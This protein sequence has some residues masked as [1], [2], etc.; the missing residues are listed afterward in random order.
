MRKSILAASTALTI[1]GLAGAAVAQTTAPV[2]PLIAGAPPGLYGV[3]GPSSAPSPGNEPGT[4]QAY[5][6]GR[7]YFDAAILSDSANNINGKSSPYS[8]GEAGR[9]YWGFQGTTTSGLTY[10]AYIE[11]RENSGGVSASGNTGAATLIYRRAVGFVAGNWGTFR[12]GGSDDPIALMMTGTFEGIGDSNWNGDLGGLIHA[13]TLVNWPFAENSGTYGNPKFVYLSPRWNGFDF[14]V[15][16]QPSANGIS[17]PQTAAGGVGDPRTT[18]ISTGTFIAANGDLKRERNLITAAAR[19]AGAMGPVGVVA[20]GGI[21]SAT[22]IKNGGLTGTT[23]SGAAPYGYRTPLAFDAGLMFTYGGFAVGGHMVTGAINPN[24]SNNFMAVA[25]GKGST[26]SFVLGASYAVGSWGF[27]TSVLQSLTPGAYAEDFAGAGTFGKR[28][29]TGY[30]ASATYGWAPNAT[31]SLSYIYGA[32]R[33]TGFNFYTS[34]K[35]TAGNNTKAQG[36]I[37]TNYFQW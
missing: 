10:G 22:T 24:G 30:V 36:L 2:N 27:S 23:V 18:S 5:V 35:S 37:L 25:Q 12:F 4:V 21:M 17:Y 11:T 33:Q 7:L 28:R 3:Y 29:E 8:I 20:E 14:G 16:F 6:R 1:V 31:L 9:L 19:Y 15:G 13:A 26:T 32:R 34:A